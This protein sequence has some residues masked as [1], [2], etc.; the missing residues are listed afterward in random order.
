[1]S[2]IVFLDDFDRFTV[3]YYSMIKTVKKTHI[4]ASSVH[5]CHKSYSLPSWPFYGLLQ[6]Y[7]EK[8]HKTH[9][10]ASS[11]QKYKKWCS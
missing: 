9:I 8:C 5:K 10:S 6:L 1:M 11:V 7:E 3:F 4:S 2:Q